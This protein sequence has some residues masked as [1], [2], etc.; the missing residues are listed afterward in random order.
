METEIK[1]G[2]ITP[3][4]AE[5]IFSNIARLS[6]PLPELLMECTYYDTRALELG[7]MKAALRLRRENGIGI[8]TLKFPSP[9]NIHS[10]EEYSE[11]AEDI[12]TGAEKL[13]EKDIPEEIKRLIKTDLLPIGGTHVTRKRMLYKAAG[14][15]AE[16]AY[17]RGRLFSGEYSEEIAELEA[18]L[19][20]GDYP[21][22]K[23]LAD[24]LCDNYGLS[25][26]KGSKHSRIFALFQRNEK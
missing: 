6:E 12:R 23:A 4:T 22:L 26:M 16:I 18:E 10:R 19:M 21:S 7:S 11:Y 2:P 17:D 3:E 1:M 15:E 25:V 14:F 24:C 5:R 13:L 20:Q 9:G 8:C